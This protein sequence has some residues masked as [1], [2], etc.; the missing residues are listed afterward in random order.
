MN[1]TERDIRLTYRYTELSYIPDVYAECEL[2]AN[3]SD[4]D[5]EGLKPGEF[6]FDYNSWSRRLGFSMKQMQRAIEELSK[7]KLVIIQVEKGKRGTCSKYFLARFE[8]KK[9]DN[10]KEDIRITLGEELSIDITGFEGS[11]GEQKGSNKDKNQDKKKD[12][13]SQYNNLN[14]ISN[15]YIVIFE[16]WNSKGIKKHKSIS[17]IMESALKAALKKYSQE[18]IVQAINRYSEVYFSDYFYNHIW[19][20]DKFLKQSNGI[21]NFLE[22]GNT[23]LNYLKSKEQLKKKAATTAKSKKEPPTKLLGWDD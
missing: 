17:N 23:W 4:K 8:D 9:K 22:D 1:L 20:L 18:E 16:H 7:K 2:R 13:S 15:I 6:R 11:S 3:I 10:N 14:I 21:S 5:Y 19:D 12:K